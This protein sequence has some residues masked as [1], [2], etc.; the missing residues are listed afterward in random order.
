MVIEARATV[1]RT[2]R[3]MS[4]VSAIAMAAGCD[5]IINCGLGMQNHGDMGS[6][7]PMLCI[8]KV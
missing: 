8:R 7:I 1:D 4:V 3:T 6:R 2:E 5:F